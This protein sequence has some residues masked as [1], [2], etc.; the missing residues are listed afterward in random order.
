V[1]DILGPIVGHD[2]VIARVSASLDLS[3]VNQNAEVV[4]P[5]SIV[6]KTEST[7]NGNSSNQSN[8]PAMVTGAV[9]NVPLAPQQPQNGPTQQGSSSQSSANKTW[10]FNKTTTQTVARIPRL[11]KLSVSVAL[12]G[13]DGKA[14]SP[15]EV[16]RL[17]ELAR[18]AVGF[19]ELRGD[20]FELTSQPFA[21]SA[22]VPE[23]PV[24]AAVTPTWQYVAMGAGV[25]A[26]LAVAFLLYRRATKKPAEAQLVLQ[27]GAT[28]AALE[29]KQNAIDGVAVE[30]PKPE[31]QP[32]L[33]DPL[34]DLKEKARGLLREDPDRALM[35]V[36]AWLS[37]DLEKQVEN[38]HG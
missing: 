14:R 9:A 28:V 19:D 31:P 36:R 23:A 12:D 38:N 5:D 4:D 2:A 22:D 35:L 21:R 13:I 8:Q 10:D 37:A 1:V 26:A 33:V 15:E 20:Q 25:L 11:T 18:K 29:A 16:S 32:L 34:Q 30:Q 3:H 24:V 17:A 6:L 27:P 7:T